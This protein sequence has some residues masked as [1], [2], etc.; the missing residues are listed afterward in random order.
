M[1]TTPATTS[2]RPLP[3]R[4]HGHRTNRSDV[5]IRH[6]DPVPQEIHGHR[7]L[8]SL[9]R[10][11]A[12]R[13][14]AACDPATRQIHTLKHVVRRPGR[15]REDQRYLDQ[16][17]NE[18]AIASRLE[19]P[20]IRGVRRI[21]RIRPRLRV[22]E[23]VLLLDFI[24]GTPL[25][26]RDDLERS[27]VLAHLAAAADAVAHLHERGVAHADL[28]PGNLILD[29]DGRIVV[30]DFGQACQI[31]TRKARVQGTPGFMPPEQRRCE[32]VTAASD[33]FSLGAT[34]LRMLIDGD[35]DG[36][37]SSGLS[38]GSVAPGRLA[39]LVEDPA[40]AASV[41]REVGGGRRLAG[42]VEHLLQADPRRRLG[43]AAT[44]AS[45]LRDLA[46]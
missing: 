3:R 28:K 36:D 7:I 4:N 26:R 23:I 17:E 39:A 2:P 40:L 45:A 22:A 32:A 19:H 14:Y 10:G 34:V 6:E 16:A 8:A 9:G 33:L 27:H 25:D 5:G 37:A 24:D 1:H 21:V 20:A 35:G 13:L 43:N 44:L 11:A 38:S 41:V 30:I 31:G 15:E 46:A 12:S 18:F 42:L 29:E